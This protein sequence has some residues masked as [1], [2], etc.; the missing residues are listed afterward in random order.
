M[1]HSSLLDCYRDIVWKAYDIF[2]LNIRN[3]NK[4]INRFR[5]YNIIKDIINPENCD[6]IEYYLTAYNEAYKWIRYVLFNRWDNTVYNC[7]VP[8][9]FVPRLTTKITLK[10]RIKNQVI[11]TEDIGHYSWKIIGEITEIGIDVYNVIPSNIIHI[12]S[13]TIFKK[14]EYTSKCIKILLDNELD[15]D[16]NLKQLELLI[17]NGYNNNEYNN[18]IVDSYRRDINL[19]ISPNTYIE[20]KT[21]III[22]YG[23]NYNDINIKLRFLI[24]STINKISN[25]KLCRFCL[26]NEN[27][28]SFFNVI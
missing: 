18:I 27:C 28:L 17:K 19:L 23:C 15:C 12:I 3:E 21:N 4:S 11:I 10:K 16:N 2:N 5:R 13:D 25:I 22:T 8:I 20:E 24:D 9:P 6:N 7:I 26:L 14:Y 1:S